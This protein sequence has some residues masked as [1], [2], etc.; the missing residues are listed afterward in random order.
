MK[1]FKK[2]ALTLAIGSL[3]AFSATANAGKNKHKHYNNYENIDY[4]RVI[5]VYPVT[6][7][8]KVSVPIEKCYDKKV[9][10]ENHHRRSHHSHKNEIVGAL[11]G[12]A[13]GNRVGKRVKGRNG[14]DIATAAGAVIGGVI[15]NGHSRRHYNHQP[16]G[17]Y[18]IV[19]HCDT[20]QDVR[21]EEKVVG[22]KVKYKYRGQVYKTRTKYH[23]GD[24]LKVRVSV[25]PY[26][27]S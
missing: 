8:I 20:Y 2:T 19:Q 12:A 14:R 26:E 22:Y 17:Y 4:A 18:K 6:K 3:V 7:Q 11:I 9:W 21:Y 10:H 27:Y 1:T 24:R 23:P 25:T 13:V 16:S 15:G 5:D